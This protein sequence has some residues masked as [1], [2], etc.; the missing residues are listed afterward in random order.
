MV[1]RSVAPNTPFFFCLLLC[2]PLLNGQESYCSS[3]VCKCCFSSPGYASAVSEQLC[4]FLA[5][6]YPLRFLWIEREMFYWEMALLTCRCTWRHLL[7]LL[8]QSLGGQ[9]G[10][11]VNESLNCFLN[12]EGGGKTTANFF[13][14][15]WLDSLLWPLHWQHLFSPKIPQPSPPPRIFSC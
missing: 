7:T 15:Y 10:T 4:V 14:A 12:L 6:M 11:S 13:S 1:R 5:L 9:L 3:Y 2:L 8:L